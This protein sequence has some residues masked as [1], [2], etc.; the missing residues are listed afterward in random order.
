[1]T[2]GVS[3]C[4]RCHH[5]RDAHTE[6]ETGGPPNRMR[7]RERCEVVGCG[8]QCYVGIVWEAPVTA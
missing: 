8:C 4:V 1:M 6:E 7:L 2:E 3:V 5:P